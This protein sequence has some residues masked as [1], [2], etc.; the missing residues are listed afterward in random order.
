M[1]LYNENTREKGLSLYSLQAQTSIWKASML[2]AA[3]AGALFSL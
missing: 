2:S 1:G 3:Q